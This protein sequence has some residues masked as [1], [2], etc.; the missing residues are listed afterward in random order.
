MIPML[1]NPPAADLHLAEMA[2]KDQMAR[3]V[4][5]GVLAVWGMYGAG[6]LCADPEAS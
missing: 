1:G 6:E 4:L 2:P 3:L 5:L